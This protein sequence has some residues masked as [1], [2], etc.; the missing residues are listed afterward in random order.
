MAIP[1]LTIEQ[2]RAIIPT[3]ADVQ[4]VDRGGQKILFS[5]LLKSTS[6]TRSPR[7]CVPPACLSGSLRTQAGPFDS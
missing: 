5:G 4:E 1:Q 7:S 3:A 2:V 6:Q